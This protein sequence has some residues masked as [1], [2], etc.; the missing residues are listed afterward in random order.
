LYNPAMKR[1][2]M[3]MVGVVIG[4]LS[5]AHADGP[6][7]SPFDVRT[8]PA[9]VST[10]AAQPPPVPPTETV[11]EH[12]ARQR[13]AALWTAAGGL[14]LVASSFAV[15]MFERHEYDVALSRGDVAGANHAQDVA[16]YVGTPL[17]VGGAVAVGVAAILYVTAPRM[18]ERRMMVSPSVGG[19]QAGVAIS[20][21]F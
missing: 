2:G 5:A 19:D 14:T 20:G 4:S 6:A 3:V 18:R 15:S 10:A 8:V 1:S 12:G 16:R 13:R 11:I 17:F 9:A 21:G 7:P